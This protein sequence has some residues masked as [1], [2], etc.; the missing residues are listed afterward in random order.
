[1]KEENKKFLMEIIES[2]VFGVKQLA[3]IV[4]AC[5][6]RIEQVKIIVN[7]ELNWEQMEQLRWAFEYGLSIEQV[8]V[9]A[10]EDF[11]WEQMEE[12]RLAFEH[13]LTVEQV[14]VIANKELDWEQ[15][16]QLR[17]AFENGAS[18]KEVQ[19]KVDEMKKENENGNVECD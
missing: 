7:P 13:G 15:M 19:Q 17:K 8:E 12:V 6:R 11:D 10:N 1:M 4:S 14:E 18:I 2:D 3:E 16:R 9:I 5:D